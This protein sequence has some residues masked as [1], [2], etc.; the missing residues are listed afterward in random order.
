MIHIKI[1]NCKFTYDDSRS[2]VLSEQVEHAVLLN[3]TNMSA[4]NKT[5]GVLR[6]FP[7][8][9]ENRATVLIP[10]SQ[11]KVPA[12]YSRTS[13][14]E[15]GGTVSTDAVE[16][17][18]SIY[19]PRGAKRITLNMANSEYYYG[20]VL[21]GAESGFIYDSGWTQGGNSITKILTSYDEDMWIAS[22]LK[23]G[24]EGTAE[25]PQ[26]TL[27]DIGWTVAVEY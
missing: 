11:V 10:K 7:Y 24:E 3:N 8:I 21:V 20:L 19:L 9:A 26:V 15:S 13:G 2:R 1:K 25:I 17:Y 18:D 14:T 4:G 23:K 16:N 12:P 22:T 6:F 5:G 27:Q